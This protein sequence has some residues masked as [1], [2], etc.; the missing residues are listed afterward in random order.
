M[1]VITF[2]KNNLSSKFSLADHWIKIQSALWKPPTFH[3]I[4]IF[5]LCMQPL[6]FKFLLLDI[7]IC[8][9]LSFN[10][11]TSIPSRAFS[12]L[13][14]LVNL[15]G[16]YFITVPNTIYY[17]ILFLHSLFEHVPIIQLASDAFN[18]TEIEHLFA[19]YLY[20][21]PNLSFI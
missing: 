18:G 19:F 10:L 5:R 4:Q 6:D 15:F 8:R 11:I 2:T 20:T 13:P 1:L 17:L 9:D 21:C 7:C 12:H 14:N 3:L 16:I